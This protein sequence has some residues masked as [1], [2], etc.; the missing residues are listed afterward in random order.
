MI[1]SNL[2]IS[3]QQNTSPKY[4]PFVLGAS[5]DM[6]GHVCSWFSYRHASR[7]QCHKQHNNVITCCA[8][9]NIVPQEGCIHKDLTT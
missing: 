6:N 8:C 2:P 7:G 9:Y 1:S 3:T 5:H 4:I